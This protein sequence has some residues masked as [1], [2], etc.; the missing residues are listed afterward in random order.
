MLRDPDQH[1]PLDGASIPQPPPATF[2]VVSGVQSPVAPVSC[3]EYSSCHRGLGLDSKLH[4]PPPV[5]DR[6]H[7]GPPH[8]EIPSESLLTDWGS[9]TWGSILLFHSRPRGRRAEDPVMF[10]EGRLKCQV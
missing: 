4:G 2:W 5:H 10:A 7:H 6:L 8:R 3:P 1:G 9:W